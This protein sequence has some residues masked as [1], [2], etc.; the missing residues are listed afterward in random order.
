MSDILGALGWSG[1][2]FMVSVFVVTNS[3]APL[4]L[5]FETGN[6]H[7]SSVRTYVLEDEGLVL[8]GLHTY[9]YD[10]RFDALPQQLESYVGECLRQACSGGTRFAWLAFEGS[11]SFGYILA[12]E[13]ADQ[14]YG[15]C[16]AGSEPV[17]VLDDSTLAS[18]VWKDEFSRL[19]EAAWRANGIS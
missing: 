6:I 19:R 13:V 14:I 15:I 11:L 12:E 3:P 10:L 2:D 7:P 5:D 9:E 8:G 18:S 4:A 1:V 17:V 16:L